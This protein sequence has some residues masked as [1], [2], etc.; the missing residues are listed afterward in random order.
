MIDKPNTDELRAAARALYETVVDIKFP[1]IAAQVGVKAEEV[2]AWRLE[3]AANGRP[4]LMASNW[5]TPA[6]E[7]KNS[8]AE[9]A[10]KAEILQPVLTETRAEA[11]AEARAVLDI[12][13]CEEAGAVTVIE[14]PHR[15]L[16]KRHRE[17]WLAPRTLSYQAMKLGQK[18][19]LEEAFTL[20]KLAK[21]SAETLT[22]IQAGEG[23]AHGMKPA[24]ADGSLVLIERG[25]S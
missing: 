16:R 19:R 4:W 1:D 25:R 10:K 13:E 22:L 11:E 5:R 9:A 6:K 8:A 18:G 23:R 17:E 7:A 15:E 3:D 2:R 24:E 20:A 12:A 21:I 14:D